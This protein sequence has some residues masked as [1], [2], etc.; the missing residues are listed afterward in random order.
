MGGGQPVRAQVVGIELDPGDLQGADTRH[1]AQQEQKQGKGN[2]EP[3]ADGQ[4]SEE[5]GVSWE[6]VGKIFDQY[7][8]NDCFPW[9]KRSLR[10]QIYQFNSAWPLP[11]RSGSAGAATQS[12]SSDLTNRRSPLAP[13]EAFRRLEVL[14]AFLETGNLAKTASSTSSLRKVISSSILRLMA[15]S[16][17]HR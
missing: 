17:S 4:K 1:H 3:C 10:N 7:D 11:P 5:H 2:D 16:R 14:L 13:G 6:A 9:L 12:S 8:V 15:T